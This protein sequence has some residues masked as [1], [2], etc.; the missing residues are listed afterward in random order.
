MIAHESAHLSQ[1]NNVK[2]GIISAEKQILIPNFWFMQKK[3][4]NNLK[5]MYNSCVIRYKS[6]CQLADAGDYRKKEGKT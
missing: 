4:G 3:H 6:I 5:P 1:D 2:F